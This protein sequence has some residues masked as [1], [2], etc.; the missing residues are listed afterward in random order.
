MWRRTQGV[1]AGSLFAAWR[2]GAHTW[3]MRAARASWPKYA[4]LLTRA[5]HP[6][7][8]QTQTLAALM[9]S[10]ALRLRSSGVS[11]D[12]ASSDACLHRGYRHGTHTLTQRWH[13]EPRSPRA[14]ETG[15][16]CTLPRFAR[17]AACPKGG[18]ADAD[19]TG[20]PRSH[21]SK[22]GPARECPGHWLTP[23]GTRAAPGRAPHGGTRTQRP[24]LTLLTSKGVSSS[25]PAPCP[26][27]PQTPQPTPF[28]VLS[29]PC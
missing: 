19:D 9:S 7:H 6:I 21:A 15:V 29:S 23:K 8:T 26:K 1:Q 18:S 4:R 22:G 11:L 24:C 3:R 27:G 5:P 28:D 2:K 20:P 16:A 13:A 12:A 10:A 25:L 14:L 17:S